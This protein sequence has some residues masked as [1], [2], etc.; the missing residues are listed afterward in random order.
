MVY[1]VV[2][3]LVAR[4]D[5]ALPVIEGVIDRLVGTMVVEGEDWNDVLSG[6]LS[7]VTL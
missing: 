1:D 3:E 2:F 5:E 7:E 6:R 4:A